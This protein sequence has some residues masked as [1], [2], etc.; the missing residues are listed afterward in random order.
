MSGQLTMA[1]A[2]S[3]LKSSASAIPEAELRA[4]RL[5]AQM[6]AMGIEPEA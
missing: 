3:S 4:E 5:A 2:A 1:P 6:R